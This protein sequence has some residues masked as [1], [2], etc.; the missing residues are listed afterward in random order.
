MTS[1]FL[2]T[3]ALLHASASD[4]GRAEIDEYLRCSGDAPGKRCFKRIIKRIR[5][6]G[7]YKDGKLTGKARTLAVVLLS[8]LALAFAVLGF[9][10]ARLLD[11]IFAAKD[12]G[13]Y[14]AVSDKNGTDTVLPYI[15]RYLEPQVGDGYQRSILVRSSRLYNIEFRGEDDSIYYT[16]TPKSAENEA[17]DD[18]SDNNYGDGLYVLIN[19]NK[20]KVTV[21]R[22]DIGKSFDICWSDDACTY[23][24]FG[25][26][27]MEDAARLAQSVYDS[28]EDPTIAEE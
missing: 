9:C 26:H 6:S 11:G 12:I 27:S 17:T 15:D 7:L 20:A 14:F 5:H 13:Q 23:R 22:T 1:N 3:D 8:L 2:P 25:A 19:G 10:F 16:Q 28:K 18:S 24:I 21:T 4:A